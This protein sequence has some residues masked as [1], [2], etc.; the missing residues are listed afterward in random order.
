MIDLKTTLCRRELTIGSWI[1]IGSPIIAEI[2]ANSG[3]DW[4]TIDM[5]HSAITLNIAQDLIRVIELCDCSPLVRIADNDP[6]LIKRIMDAGAHGII[7]PAEEFDK[8]KT[9]FVL[10]P[11]IVKLGV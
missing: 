1:T 8:P 5:E 3:F 11:V 10:P 2:M 4:L 9:L 7:V 6:V